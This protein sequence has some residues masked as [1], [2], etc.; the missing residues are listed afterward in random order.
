MPNLKSFRVFLDDRLT[1]VAVEIFGAFEK[2]VVEYQEENDRLR[3]LLRITPGTKL[4]EID[5]LQFSLAVSEEEVPPEQQPCEQE[6]KTILEQDDPEPTQVKEEQAEHGIGQEEEQLQG[7]QPNIIEFTF[8]PSCVKYERDQ[9]DPLSL[10]PP[11]TETVA[12]RES[13]S[14]AVDLTH[15]DAVTYIKGLDIPCDHPDNQNHAFTHNSSFNS[16]PLGLYSSSQLQPGPPQDPYPALQKQCSNASTS[17]KNTYC[18]RDCDETFILK[19]DLQMHLTL[20]K[21]TVS[22][23]RFCQKRYNSACKLKAHVQ[24]CHARKTCTCP[25]CGKTFNYKEDLLRHTRIHTGE[26][27]LSCGDCG[28]RF[29][30][31]GDLGKHIMTHTGEKRFRCGDCGKSF[32]R[33]W[34]LTDHIRTHT[35]EKPFSCGDCGK[36]FNQKGTL[37]RHI[38][39][40]TREKLLGCSVCSKRFTHKNNLLKHVQSIHKDIRLEKN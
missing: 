11:Q 19:A 21:K 8:T 18:C 1:A 36:S 24:L 29:S 9:V 38:R 35:G 28:K 25:V 22:E 4:C 17:S 37:R 33:K 2:M 39:T 32:N 40:H 7:L 3:R 12:N 15:F 34:N 16:D 10:T 20:A 26:T 23:C 31:K 14:K 27:F 5:S 6:W 13:D 30:H